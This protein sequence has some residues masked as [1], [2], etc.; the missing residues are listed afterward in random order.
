LLAKKNLTEKDREELE[1]LLW[2]KKMRHKPFREATGSE[3]M[4]HGVW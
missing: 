3:F 2:L 1:N 4:M